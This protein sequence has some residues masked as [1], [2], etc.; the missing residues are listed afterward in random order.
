MV[1]VVV[2][3]VVFEGQG[4]ITWGRESQ[5]PRWESPRGLDWPLA[6]LQLQYH[7]I[8]QRLALLLRYTGNT[9]IPPF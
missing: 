5:P 2:V 9:C 6:G 3:V 8:L 1:V 4:N 7:C